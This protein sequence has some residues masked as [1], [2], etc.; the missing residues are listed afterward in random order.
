MT[1]VCTGLIMPTH[2]R[3]NSLGAHEDE[4][5]PKQVLVQHVVLYV[6]RVVLH[7]ERQ[8][9][10]NQAQQLRR[11][12]RLCSNNDTRCSITDATMTTLQWPTDFSETEEIAKIK[13]KIHSQTLRAKV[14]I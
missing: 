5:P 2:Q 7:A 3:G 13:T 4:H 14:T 6:V 9:L 12:A 1:A 8:Q 11:L 10:H